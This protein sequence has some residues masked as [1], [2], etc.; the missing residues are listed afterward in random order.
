MPIT[1]LDYVKSV[2]GD[3]DFYTAE[4]CLAS[5]V[6]I[7]G[8]CQ[9]CQ[10]IIAVYNAYP[11]TSGYW[12]CADCIGE[13]GYATV[14]DFTAH[15]AAITACPSCG[16]TDTSARPAS[17][18]ANAPRNTRWNAATADRSGSHDQHTR[19]RMARRDFEQIAGRHAGDF[20]TRPV[21]ASGAART[22]IRPMI[23][24]LSVMDAG[25][26]MRVIPHDYDDPR[27][28]VAM[29]ARLVRVRIQAQL[30]P[31]SGAVP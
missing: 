5:G 18:P 31:D 12:R 10:A 19:H 13:D 24:F 27:T 6:D 23:E 3:K 8:G 26:R 28:V 4:D 16:N 14:A 17:P 25:N 21:T 7:L 2:V 1:I 29:K 30:H 11:S 15:E 20:V 22:M 9:G